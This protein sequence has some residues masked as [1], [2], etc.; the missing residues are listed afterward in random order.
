MKR[1]TSQIKKSTIPVL[2]LQHAT[3]TP[4]ATPQLPNTPSITQQQEKIVETQLQE[5]TQLEIIPAL[6]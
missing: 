6:Q 2:I 5:D 1:T 4:Q 3:A